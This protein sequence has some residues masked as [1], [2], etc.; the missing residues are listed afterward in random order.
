MIMVHS[1]DMGLVLPPRVAQTQVVVI[2][3]VKKGDDIE[4]IK[5]RAEEIFK[6]LKKA[7]IRVEFDDRDNYT[8]GHKFNHHELRGVPIR[9]ELG[10]MDFDKQE[11]RVC[12]R[13]DGAKAQ[14]KQQ[15]LA[16]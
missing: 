2:P 7:G 10:K 4:T 14:Y 12:K 15:G 8:P 9:I 1:D 6:D 13:H 3:I 5:N 16:D 11:V